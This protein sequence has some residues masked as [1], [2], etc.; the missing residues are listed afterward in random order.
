[1]SRSSIALAMGS[2][3][4]D[5]LF[6]N[7]LSAEG[8]LAFDNIKAYKALQLELRENWSASL[9]EAGNSQLE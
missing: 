4:S 8:R 9:K 1:S 5:K 7:G 2:V 3:H 6:R